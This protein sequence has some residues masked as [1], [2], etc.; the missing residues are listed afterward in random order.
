MVSTPKVAIVSIT[1]SSDSNRP[2]SASSIL[3]WTARRVFQS[4]WQVSCLVLVGATGSRER[5]NHQGDL[6]GTGQTIEVPFAFQR[7]GEPAQTTTV[8]DRDS[9]R[10]HREGTQAHREAV[11]LTKGD[12]Q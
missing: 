3:E 11:A 12:R 10:R 5:V 2:F 7:S 4:L 6:V 1:Q 8:T 9:Q